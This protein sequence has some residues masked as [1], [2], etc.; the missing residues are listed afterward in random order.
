MIR[1]VSKSYIETEASVVIKNSF[2]SFIVWASSSGY[3]G[4][5]ILINNIYNKFNII[6]LFSEYS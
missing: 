6:D 2:Y 1:Y 3:H 5:K 4:R